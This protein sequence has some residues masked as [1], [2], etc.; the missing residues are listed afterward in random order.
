MLDEDRPLRVLLLLAA[1]LLAV[2]TSARAQPATFGAADDPAEQLRRFWWQRETSVSVGGGVSLIGPQWRGL[3]SVSLTTVTRTF[4]AHLDGTLRGGLYGSYAPDTDETYDLARLVRFVRYNA[5]AGAPVYLRAG[6]LHG[7]R[8]GTGHVV[9]FFASDAA[10]DERTVGLE[11]AVESRFASLAGFTDDA[12]FGGV[13]GGRLALRPLAFSANR[14]A[15]SLTVG[16]S[17]ITDRA[18]R[19]AA[20]PDSIAAL[21]AVAA[22]VAFDVLDFGG[23]ALTPFASFATYTNY[24]HGV[25]AGLDLASANFIDLARFRLRLAYYRSTDRFL[26]GYVGA[27]YTVNSPLAR[28]VDADDFFEDNA[29]EELEGTPLQTV[30]AGNGLQTELRL[31]LFGQLELRSAFYRHYG[32]QNLSIYHLRLFV[33]AGE[34]TRL[35]LS[36]DRTGLGDLFRLFDPLD[37]ETLLSLGLSYGILRNVVADVRARYTFE[38]LDDAPGGAPRFLPERRFEPTL[39]LRIAL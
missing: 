15:Q 12:R 33:Q 22:D 4:T 18:L 32:P 27:L 13:M 34:Q 39:R 11:G 5:P 37:D 30:E 14:R 20:A 23:I 17:A 26:P 1:V 21:T 29:A 38:R 8:L 25:S 16:A 2:G 31:L 6:P 19:P 24:G 9:N 7:M 10:W 35:D 3:A 28:I 36:V